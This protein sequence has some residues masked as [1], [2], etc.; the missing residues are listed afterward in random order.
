MN[1][2]HI[3]V[4]AP[5]RVC[6]FGE[7]LDYLGLFVISAAI[8]LFITISGSTRNDRFLHIVMPDLKEEEWID[9]GKPLTYQKPRDYL[10]SAV[11]VLRRHGVRVE[12]GCDCI[13][14]GNLPIQA[15]VS[16]SSAFVIAWIVFLLSI[17]DSPEVMNRQLV[18]GFGYEAEV[19]EFNE[20]GGMMDHFTSSL[21]GV[22]WLDCREPFT[23]DRIRVD[24]GGIVLGD[25]L[26][27]KPTT[28]VLSSVRERV[29]AGTGMLE[30]F[31]PSFDL[32]N[33]SLS[34]VE[35]HLK[36][37]PEETQRAVRSTL[38]NRD[39]ALE[40]KGVLKS[41][42]KDSEIGL[43]RLLSRH[44]EQLR[45]GLSISTPKVERMIAAAM[46]NGALGC[47]INGS[48]G[49]GCMLAYAPSREQQVAEAIQSEGG[50]AYIVSVSEGVQVRID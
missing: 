35:P 42:Q 4:K 3:I 48:G 1:S 20:P 23:A 22:L 29:Q 45:D 21:G 38:I 46:R 49:G 44:H 19:K 13:L 12:H 5:G 36:S 11:N 16:S 24:L 43:G 10:R 25:S 8:D 31:I 37:L 39:I 2:P 7:H 50:K 32:Q 34:E 9:L 6:L 27:K 26:E 18:A 15:G 28:R 17:A 14:T 40:A 41:W 47:K 33:T 30:Q